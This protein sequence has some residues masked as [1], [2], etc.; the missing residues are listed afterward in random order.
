MTKAQA[1]ARNGK[2]LFL[3]LALPTPHTPIAP[4]PKWRRKPGLNFYADYVMETDAYIGQVLDA[5]DRNG[6]TK[7]T[8]VLLTS[9]NGCSPEANIPFLKAHG[10][11]PSDGRRGYKADIYDGGHRIPLLARWPGKITAGSQ[12]KA[13]ICLGD[14]MATCAELTQVKLPDNAAEDSIS[15]LPLLP[16]HDNP[17]ARQ[18]F[19]S[20]RVPSTVPSVFARENGSWRSAPDRAAGANPVPE[21]NRREAPPS[22]FSILRTI[23]PKRRMSSTTTRMS[24]EHLGHLLRDYIINGRSTPGPP[25]PNTPIHSAWKQTAWMEKFK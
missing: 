24:S 10:H 13:F 15:F 8:L 22:S 6:L 17:A 25:Q 16:G 7:N 21:R 1:N 11:D 2:P 12:T 5:L 18:S 4:S 19:S 20:S 23:P 3:F 14:F 9:D